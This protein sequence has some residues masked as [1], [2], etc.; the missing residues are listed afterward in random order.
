[1]NFKIKSLKESYLVT[2]VA[3]SFIL[4]INGAIPYIAVPTF[5]QAIWTSGFAISLSNAPILSI[6]AN[7]IGFPNPAG[8]AFGLSGALPMGALIKFGMSPQDAYSTTVAFW[9]II[10]YISCSAICKK[11]NLTPYVRTLLSVLWTSQPIIW[12]HQDFSMLAS[13]IALLSLYFYAAIQLFIVPQSHAKE[14]ILP[15]TLYLSCCLVS[16]FMD[17]YT[18]MMFAVGSSIMGACTLFNRSTRRSTIL[19]ALPTHII[20]FGIAY[21][22]YTAYIGKSHF[23]PASMDFF[24]G[25]GADIF[26]FL[27]PTKGINW[28]WDALNLSVTRTADNLFGDASVWNTTF[29]LPIIITGLITWIFS[30]EKSRLLNAMFL[31]SLFGFYMSL[32]PSLKINTEKLGIAGAEMPAS[33]AI[34]PTGSALISENLPGF[35]NMR[36]AYRWTALGIFGL[37]MILVISLSDQKNNSHKKLILIASIFIIT[38]NLPHIQQKF[39]AYKSHRNGF[40]GIERDLVTPLNQDTTDNEIVAYL[41]YRND[42]IATFISPASGIKTYNIGGDKNVAIARQFWPPAIKNLPNGRIDNRLVASTLELLIRKQADAVIFPHIDFHQDFYS[43]PAQTK[44]EDSL[45]PIIEKLLASG[46]IEVKS[47]KYYSIAR[48][49]EIQTSNLPLPEEMATNICHDI[50]PVTAGPQSCALPFILADGWYAI[51]ESNVWSS[52]K[53]TLRIYRPLTCKTDKCRV[54]VKFAVYGASTNRPV[55]LHFQWVNSDTKSEAIPSLSVNSGALQKIV[56]SLSSKEDYRDLAI[57]IPKAIS[58]KALNGG[59][60]NRVLGISLYKLDISK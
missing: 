20:S 32:G 57:T 26:Y 3:I 35:N 60:D 21:Y 55:H 34:A 17:G 2:L 58:P 16:I 28:L 9:L 51:E 14:R 25:W 12:A 59:N 29:A 23:E 8:I 44:F 41:P 18:F 30:K 42:F 50:Y 31:L 53:A 52:G 10:S 38:S 47:R 54:S 4:I 43:W 36:A 11:F 22:L 37:W 46:I 24:R 33:A 27:A 15:I 39:A 5:G 40:I 19:F 1:M 49:K 6:Y 45:S 7:N 56:L 13:G 48:L